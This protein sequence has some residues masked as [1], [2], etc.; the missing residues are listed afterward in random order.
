MIAPEKKAK[1]K[2][3]CRRGMLELDLILNEFMTTHFDQLSPVKIEQ[4]EALL[5]YPDPQLY[6]WLIGQ[7][8]PTDQELAEIVHT[9]RA[10]HST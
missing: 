10:L 1:I 5:T 6:V 4:L 3:Q 8:E 7:E 2:W 9:I